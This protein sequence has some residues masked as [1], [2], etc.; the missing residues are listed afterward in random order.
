MEGG[1]ELGG[2]EE[3]ETI[4]KIYYERGGKTIFSKR[5]THSHTKDLKLICNDAPQGLSK[6][7]DFK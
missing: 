2:I 3:G 4:V 7:S 5:N 6:M 1:E